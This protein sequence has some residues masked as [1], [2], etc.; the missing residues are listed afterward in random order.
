MFCSTA[1]YHRLLSH[2]SWIAPRWIEVGGTF[3]GIFTFTGTPITRTLS[4]RYHHEFTETKLDPHSPQI[5]GVFKTYFPMLQKDIKMDLRYVSDLIN[6]PFHRW[7]HVNYLQIIAGVVI[8]SLVAW[9]LDWTI[10]LFIAPGALCW[11]N[12]SICN[13]L[14]HFGKKPA[15]VN[16]RALSLLTFGEGWHLNHHQHPTRAAFSNGHLDLGYCAVKI[17]QIKP[18]A[19]NG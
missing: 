1:I 19:K 12:I 3:I 10:T 7:C 13:I 8:A 17:M 5:I 16:S 18:Q 4:H 11:M 6:D 15:I 9:G 14:C 2:R